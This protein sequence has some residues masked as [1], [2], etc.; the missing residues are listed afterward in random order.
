MPEVVTDF[1]DNVLDAPDSKAPRGVVAPTVP[2]IVFAPLVPKVRLDGPLITFEKPT[3]P[4]PLV[5]VKFVDSLTGLLNE[6]LPV[7]FV[8][9]EEALVPYL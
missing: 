2:E 7:T 9:E 5:I 6:I 8:V 1:I 3:V 4:V